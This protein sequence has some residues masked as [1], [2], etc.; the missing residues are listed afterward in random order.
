MGFPGGSAVKKLPVS[1]GDLRDT[2]SIPGLRRSLG[3]GHGDPLQYSCLENPMDR[4][5]W[6]TT[7]HRVAKS[8]TWLRAW[9]FLLALWSK[10]HICRNILSFVSCSGLFYLTA[11]GL[12]R[13]TNWFLTLKA[14]VSVLGLAR[15]L[16]SAWAVENPQ[17][18]KY[19]CWWPNTEK[20]G[21][22]QG[23]LGGKIKEK[24]SGGNQLSMKNSCWSFTATSGQ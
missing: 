24:R 11:C 1:A 22:P 17:G 14:S 18:E 4:G 3:G 2:G 6:C 15:L 21:E 5:A 9:G 8:Q 16:S 23:L 7:V 12:S 10:D 20:Q 19:F 13:E